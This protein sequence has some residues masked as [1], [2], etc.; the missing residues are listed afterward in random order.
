MFVPALLL[1]M[2]V[3]GLQRMRRP[4]KGGAAIARGAA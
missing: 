3:I 1:L 2:M 4:S